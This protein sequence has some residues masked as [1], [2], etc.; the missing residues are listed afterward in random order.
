MY[1][2]KATCRSDALRSIVISQQLLG[3]EEIIVMHHTEC[4]M[5][6]F[7]DDQIRT[8]LRESVPASA[9]AAVDDIAFLPFPDLGKRAIDGDKAG[10][11]I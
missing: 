3:T 11:L 5:L 9:H 7:T 2:A 6:I 10:L 4:G 1:S 8:K